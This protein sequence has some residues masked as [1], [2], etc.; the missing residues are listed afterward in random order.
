[1]RLLYNVFILGYLTFAATLLLPNC[2]RYAA[3]HYSCI[4]ELPYCHR[5][6]AGNFKGFRKYQT[7]AAMLLLPVVC[8]K[9][10]RSAAFHRPY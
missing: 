4:L 8:M 5:Y 6:T 10:Q 3:L 9:L 2:R 1:M 7:I